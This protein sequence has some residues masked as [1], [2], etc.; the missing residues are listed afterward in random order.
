MA[1]LLRM[2]DGPDRLAWYVAPTHRQ[3]KDSV[4]S[5]LKSFL[6]PYA[7]KAHE[8]D[9]SITLLSGG[10]IA[11]RSADNYDSLRGVGLDGLVLDE[12]A[13]IPKE[14][15]VEALR[16]MLSDRGGRALFIGTPKGFNHF[17]DLYQDGRADKAGWASWQF[18]TLQ[19]GRVPADEIEA[20]RNEMDRNTFQQEYEASFENI[21]SGRVYYCFDRADHVEPL[22]YDD[23]FD[24]NWSLDFN[25]DPMSSVI[26]QVHRDY[27]G[28]LTVRVLEEISIPA[29]TQEACEEFK[30]RFEK[31]RAGKWGRVN[32]RVYGDPAGNQR[33]HAGPSDWQA[34]WDS[35]RSH[36][37]INTVQCVDTA[38]PGIRDRVNAVN[39]MLKNAAGLIRLKV[40]PKC[41]ELI[42]DFERCLW[43]VDS[44]KNQ[45]GELSKK[46]ARRNHMSDALGYAIYR[47]FGAKAPT[48][49]V[50]RHIG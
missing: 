24:L 39:A 42:A 29:K 3:A 14:A 7:T 26:F 6:G 10:R 13:D 18:T 8:T 16:P 49:A 44:N 36:P 31:L 43:A 17:Y 4:W 2:A 41:K 12:Y 38:A 19:G 33:Q 9:L 25:I 35:F 47:D 23:R 46:D 48:G 50:A 27:A 22:Q 34:V 21:G 1:E 5:Q 28:L 40:D 30:R 37:A 20:A 45:I 11:L 32:V 15:W